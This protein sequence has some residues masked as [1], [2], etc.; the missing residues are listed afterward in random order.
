MEASIGVGLLSFLAEIP[1]PRSRH[2]RRHR[3]SAILALVCGAIMSGAR[4]YAA[5]G[6]WG[7]DQDITLMHR[8][9]FTRRPPK[10]GGIRKVLIALDVKAFEAA[11]T[12]W[13]EAN[14]RQPIPRG[15]APLEAFALDGKSARGSF[16]GLEKAVHL[17]SLMAHGSGLTLAQMAVPDGVEDKTNEHKT[18]LRLLDGVALE[19]RVVTGD[20]IFCQRDLSQQ[21]IDAQGHFLW[22]V[23]ENQPTLLDD[24][25][26]AFAPSVEG[27]FS[28]S[29]AT[30]LGGGD[31]D[32][33]D[34][35]Q[36][37]WPVRTPDAEGDHGVERVSGLARCRAGGAGRERG[38]AGR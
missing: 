9:G 13:A 29:A 4:S 28:P 27:A 33:D 31:G 22:F 10:A 34:P 14:L 15:P 6:Q 5:I 1:D 11:L 32:R 26:A 17:L 7:Q 38:V 16:D 30:V 36:G 18:A 12:R 23:K 20:A 19:G 3:L 35:R 21:V 2:G 37:A 24:I 8:L 25:E